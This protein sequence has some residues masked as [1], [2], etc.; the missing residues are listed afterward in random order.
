MIEIDLERLGI[1][2]LGINVAWKWKT[3]SNKG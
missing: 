2:S 3:Q 1:Q